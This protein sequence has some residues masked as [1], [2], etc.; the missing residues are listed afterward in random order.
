MDQALLEVLAKAAGIGGLALGVFLLIFRSVIRKNIFP[1][2]QDE[3]AYR[4][5]RLILVLT[6]LI[7]T[8]GIGAW[9]FVTIGSASPALLM[10]PQ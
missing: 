7:A 1:K 4:L 3:S 6:F 9:I 8:L 10:N 2:L 5:I